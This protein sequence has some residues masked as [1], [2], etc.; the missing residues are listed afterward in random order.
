MTKI[1]NFKKRKDF[2]RVAKGFHVATHNMV[3]QAARSLSSS[4]DIYVGYTSTK[5]IGN[6]V[7][8]NKSRRRL[9]AVIREVLVKHAK[10]Q[11]DYVFIARSTTATCC[12]NELCRDVIYALKRINKNFSQQPENNTEENSVVCKADIYSNSKNHTLDS[13]PANVAIPSNNDMSV[14]DKSHI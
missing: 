13:S 12:F 2:L 11:V 8:R 9:R 7:I 10:P 14:A 6:A 3:L 5:R 4:S 1:F